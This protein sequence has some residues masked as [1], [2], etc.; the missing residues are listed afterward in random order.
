M[1]MTHKARNYTSAIALMLLGTALVLS[2]VL[3]I[4][5]FGQGPDREKVEEQASFQV[6]QPEPPEQE[7][8]DKEPEP[9]PES[10]PNQPPPSP[11][12]GL[13]T[14]VGAGGFEIAT[15]ELNEKGMGGLEDNLV[16][17]SDDVVMTDDAV[18]VAPKPAKRAPLEYPSGARQQGVTGYV[19]V[20]LLINANGEVER[21]KVLESEPGDTFEQV[22]VES[23]R[24]WRFQPAKY[25]GDK[26]KVWA[27]QK[28]RFDLS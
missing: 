6:E 20:N 19:V 2:T 25:E 16:G 5:R 18:D 13:G 1:A 23:V 9:E 10:E 21:V 3:L 28:I 8:V 12:E 27:K 11:L 17:D 14:D 15:P 4:N 7:E 24:K 26:V 22:A